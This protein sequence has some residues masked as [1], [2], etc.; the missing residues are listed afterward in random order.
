MRV[1]RSQHFCDQGCRN[2]THGWIFVNMQQ[3]IDEAA[4]QLIA[5]EYMLR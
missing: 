2:S 3:E 5:K 1:V 4:R